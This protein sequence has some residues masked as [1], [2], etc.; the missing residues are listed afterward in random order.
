[1]PKKNEKCKKNWRI[2]A[3]FFLRQSN[4][5]VKT[6]LFMLKENDKTN[7]ESRF[8]LSPSKQPWSE[9]QVAN[10]ECFRNVHGI[11]FLD[12]L[13]YPRLW[14]FVRHVLLFIFFGHK[15]QMYIAVIPRWRI[16]LPRNVIFNFYKDLFWNNSL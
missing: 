11:L 2:F 12:L 9:I 7:D 14:L 8:V 1:M 10:A 13:W 15:F 5:E 16:Y 4:L 6:T 3:L